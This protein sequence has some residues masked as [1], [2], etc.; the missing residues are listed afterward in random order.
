ME[1]TVDEVDLAK[2]GLRW[3]LGHPRPMFHRD[4]KVR[5]ALHPEPGQQ[6]DLA[7]H[8]L[9]HG[10]GRT[11]RNRL[12]GPAAGWGLITVLIHPSSLPPRS[13]QPG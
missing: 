2:V 5:I 4:P 7:N 10:V 3:V 12:N 6:V 8:R 13:Q 9:G 11:H 1:F